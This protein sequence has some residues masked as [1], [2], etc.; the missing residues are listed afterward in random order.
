ME[1]P[2]YFLLIFIFVFTVVFQGVASDYK[3]RIYNAYISNNMQSWK[4]IIDE[5][6]NSKNK[7]PD[8]LLELVNYQYGYIGFCLGE[9]NDDDAE[10]YLDLAINNLE[11]LNK[12]GVNPSQVNAFQSAFYGY[13]IGLNKLKAPF[14]GPKS[15]K[16]SRLAM[17]QNPE[18]PYGYIQFANG[19]FH[20]PPVFGGSKKV[21][22]EYFQKAEVLMEKNKAEIQNDWNYLSLLVLIGQ[23]FEIQ[24]DFN[25]AK[26]YYEKALKTEPNFLW[27]KNELYPQLLQKI[28]HTK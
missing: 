25:N 8:F 13:S 12:S 4:S 2:K 14:L 3:I 26:K 22:A 11:K 16:H 5:M 27:V 23:S 10:K 15:V 1:R 21:A 6:E 28:K 7:N 19:E 9:N 18:N 20:M 17:E 24:S